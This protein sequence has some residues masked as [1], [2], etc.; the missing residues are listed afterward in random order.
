MRMHE[1]DVELF[2]LSDLSTAMLN[3]AEKRMD[4]YSDKVACV[5]GEAEN[6]KYNEEKFDA[7]YISGAMHHFSDY[8]ASI[9][10]QEQI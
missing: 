4:K 5:Q 8:D 10:T 1:K 3:V 6:F 9:K 7:I 2:V